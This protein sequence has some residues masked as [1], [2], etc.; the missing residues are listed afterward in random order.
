MTARPLL[1]LHADD[2]GI[3]RAVTDGILDAV[4]R[5]A[6]TSTSVLANAPDC[7]RAIAAWKDLAPRGPACDFGV[8][9]NL[10]QGRP[11]TGRRYPRE[12]L[13]RHGRFP[14]IGGL[15][16]RLLAASRAQ[17][18][19]VHQELAAQ[20]E[21]VAQLGVTITHL[22]GHQYVELLPPV[23]EAVFDLANNYG[24][25]VVRCALE[26]GMA[27]TLRGFGI[28]KRALAEVKRR[29]A[30]QFAHR[31]RR[32]DLAAPGHFFGTAHA[33]QIDS[34]VL[35]RFLAIARQ[36]VAEAAIVEIGMHPALPACAPTASEVHDGWTD[37]LARH[38]PGEWKLLTQPDLPQ[39]I[40]DAGFVPGRLANLGSKTRMTAAA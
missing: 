18:R 13:D 25:G 16:V 20:I 7:L 36:N 14:G 24:I 3:N 26:R 10:T 28:H 21:R 31:L 2:F 32:C 11:L 5:G 38:R 23:R 12:L 29:F 30:V 17:R 1:V 9:L 33:G 22:N 34:A 15:F 39:Q 35:Q 19:A 40:L 6:L 27:S 8:H 37:P 4:S